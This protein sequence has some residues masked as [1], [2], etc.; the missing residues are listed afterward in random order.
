MTSTRQPAKTIVHISNIQLPK[1][2]FDRR[3]AEELGHKLE[4]RLFMLWAGWN[5]L[6]LVYPTRSEWIGINLLKRDG[7]S[8]YP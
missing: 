5:G 2:S 1:V 6:K 4:A 3:K 8:P 7:E